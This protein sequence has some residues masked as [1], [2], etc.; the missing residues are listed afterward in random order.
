[1]SL[2][3]AVRNATGLLI[4]VSCATLGDYFDTPLRTGRVVS[5]CGSVMNK[6]LTTNERPHAYVG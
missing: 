3:S 6:Q 5:G 1:M 2:R 4:G